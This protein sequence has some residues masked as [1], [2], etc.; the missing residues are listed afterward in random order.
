MNNTS[1]K[2]YF[3]D[4]KESFLAF[5]SYALNDKSFYPYWTMLSNN[6][7]FNFIITFLYH[8]SRFGEISNIIYNNYDIVWNYI[9][10]EMELEIKKSEDTVC[11]ETPNWLY[12]IIVAIIPSQFNGSYRSNY[13]IESIYSLLGQ[14]E[15]FMF[16][17]NM[18]DKVRDIVSNLGFSYLVFMGQ[19][20]LPREIDF[21]S[22]NLKS[23]IKEKLRERNYFIW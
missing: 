16:W 4:T 3:I 14:R 13:N 20:I 1:E 17:D 2:K 8:P 12:D 11:I 21:H 15:F 10:Q 19:E 9:S 6:E 23:K 18:V 22:Y 5:A 7:K